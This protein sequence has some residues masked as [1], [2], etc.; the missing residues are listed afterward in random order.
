MISPTSPDIPENIEEIEKQIE[1]RL[2]S[3]VDVTELPDI[4]SMPPAAIGILCCKAM[5]MTNKMISE[6]LNVDLSLP[7]YYRRTYDPDRKFCLNKEQG[8]AL[9]AS[10]ARSKKLAAMAFI[11]STKLRASTADQLASV[12]MKLQRVE[13]DLQGSGEKPTGSR[14][15]LLIEEITG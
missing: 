7:D 5:G 1:S 4:R 15:A 2:P 3:V 12:A 14:G 9:M 13:T 10:F 6:W 8:R 11:D